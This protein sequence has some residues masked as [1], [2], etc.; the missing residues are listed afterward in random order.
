MFIKNETTLKCTKDERIVLGMI[1]KLYTTTK[2][3]TVPSRIN[4]ILTNV[5]PVLLEKLLKK[6]PSIY[7]NGRFGN[8]HEQAYATSNE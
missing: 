5:H 3:R 8:T 7:K 1:H 6:H 2:Q 4:D